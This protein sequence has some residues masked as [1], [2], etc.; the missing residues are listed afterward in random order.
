MSELGEGDLEQLGVPLGHK[1]KFM[2]KIKQLKAEFVT[3]EKPKTVTSH[4]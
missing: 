3:P 1:L 4:S 2:K